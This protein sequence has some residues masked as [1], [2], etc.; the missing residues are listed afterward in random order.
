MKKPNAKQIKDPITFECPD[1]GRKATVE[2]C[3][4]DHPTAKIGVLQC[5]KCDDGDFHE[6]QW[7]TADR[8]PLD[9]NYWDAA[10]KR[11]KKGSK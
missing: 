9:D 10:P 1:C 8:K 11:G 7:F 6:A 4:M 3:V 5:P 2:R